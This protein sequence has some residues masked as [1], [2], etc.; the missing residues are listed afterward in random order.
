MTTNN[1]SG[2][3]QIILSHLREK[4][5]EIADLSDVDPETIL[6]VCSANADLH[7]DIIWRR[8]CDNLPP[9]RNVEDTVKHEIIALCKEIKATSGTQKSEDAAKEGGD[10]KDT[11]DLTYK[12]IEFGYLIV[13]PAYKGVSISVSYQGEFLVLKS[14]KKF[15]FYLQDRTRDA[16]FKHIK[17]KLNASDY[18]RFLE[19]LI[20]KIEV[21]LEAQR[22]HENAPQ[23]E[24]NTEEEAVVYTDEVERRA[25]ALVEDPALF[26]K[27]GADLETGFYLPGVN[28]IRYI[29]GE[30]S[31]KRQIAIHM[32][33]SRWGHDT[34]NIISGGFATVKDTLAKMIFHMTGTQIMQRGFLTAAAMRYSKSMNTASVLYL[35]EAEMEGERGRQM[36]L[37]RPDDAGFV[38]EYA[39]KNPE[40][41]V[42]ETETGTVDIKTLLI[43]TNDIAFDQALVSGGWVFN[44]DD[45]ADLT[46]KVIDAKL[47]DFKEDKTVLSK[48]DVDTWHRAA[49]ILTNPTEI[50]TK[51]RIPYASNLDIL[52]SANL[53]QSRRSPEKLCELIQDVAILRRYQK[54]MER[55]AIADIID[56]FIALRIGATA[57]METISEASDKES[58]I[59][60]VIGVTDKYGE[61]VTAKEIAH[62]APYTSNTCYA[63]AETLT[64]KGY[65][66]KGKKGRENVYSIK[67]KLSDRSKLCLTLIKSLD[68]PIA[69]L[70]GC[71]S[72]VYPF[73]E[74]FNS[75]EMC[76]VY[77][78]ES[79]MEE[80]KGLSDMRIIDPLK[81]SYIYLSLNPSEFKSCKISELD[82]PEGKE[83]DSFTFKLFIR[84]PKSLEEK[85]S[86]TEQAET[87][88]EN[89]PPKI[90]TKSGEVRG[91]ISHPEDIPVIP[92][93]VK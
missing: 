11:I 79:Q 37:M 44:T 62:K 5:K 43:T 91:S 29:L 38:Y 18:M 28:R 26:Y 77:I 24:T 17:E 22:D 4:L 40:T 2:D 46:A 30:Q 33:A 56:L 48:E 74:L 88:T 49:D 84:D 53:S 90:D 76:K 14:K 19:Q 8:L 65:L 1:N 80:C 10:A 60:N 59:C 51:I 54:P 39:R 23:D 68:T 67:N 50:P 69:V 31:L 9:L 25:A 27:L 85:K 75:D 78:S 86:T 83:L 45:G 82:K 66:A 70:K 6:E 92:M 58:E 3:E 72:I 15:D 47:R 89:E 52:F 13:E 36:R 55:R 87:K 61:G 34:I 64:S 41:G 20:P 81:N 21:V 42:M 7:E 63:L 12:D 93:G 32:M 16:I 57:I 73:L 71:I 35:S